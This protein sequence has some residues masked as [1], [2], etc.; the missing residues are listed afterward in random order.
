[1]RVPIQTVGVNRFFAE[2]ISTSGFQTRGCSD[3]GIVGIELSA[4]CCSCLNE[5]ERCCDIGEE[6]ICT[7]GGHSVCRTAYRYWALMM[8]QTGSGLS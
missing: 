2:V 3:H 5:P 1:M 4:Q 8:S 7:T 6:C